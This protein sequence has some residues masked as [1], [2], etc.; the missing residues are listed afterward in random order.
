MRIID[1]DEL[2]EHACRD[3]LDS[4]EL[5]MKMIENAPTVKDTS[6]LIK[7]R[8]RIKSAIELLGTVKDNEAITLGEFLGLFNA[9][10]IIDKEIENE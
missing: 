5:I 10:I 9:F 2:M 3:K 8:N 6:S 4:R 7:I 1:A